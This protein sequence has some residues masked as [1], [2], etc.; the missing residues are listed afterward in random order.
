MRGLW[1]VAAKV[2]RRMGIARDRPRRHGSVSG[3]VGAHLAQTRWRTGAPIIRRHW[4]VSR[5]WGAGPWFACKHDSGRLAS[6]M[7]CAEVCHRATWEWI[8]WSFSTAFSCPH[9]NRRVRLKLPTPQWPLRVPTQHP[10]TFVALQVPTSPGT[11]VA[12]QVPTSTRARSWPSS[13]H[14]L[15]A[16]C[17]ADRP[18]RRRCRR[19]WQ[20]CSGCRRPWSPEGRSGPSG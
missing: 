4:R 20:P 9:G 15:L 5:S 11:F 2:R 13:C 12:L 6:P 7:I 14:S 16:R 3:P 8:S 10:G 1:H 18:S 17:M 19:R